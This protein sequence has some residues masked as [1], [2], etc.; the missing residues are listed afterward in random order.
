ML[1]KDDVGPDTW[2]N[3]SAFSLAETQ[4]ELFLI[5][6]RLLGL[7]AV[8]QLLIDTKSSATRESLR[9][10]ANELTRVGLKPLAALVREHARR[11][12]PASPTFKT[13]WRR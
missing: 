13:R 1:S 10:A 8:E 2:Q 9:V 3:T 7:P 5:V 11:A 12:K 4:A 6:E